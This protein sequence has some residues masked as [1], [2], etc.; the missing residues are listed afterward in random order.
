[1]TMNVQTFVCCEKKNLSEVVLQMEMLPDTKRPLPVLIYS[2]KLNTQTE[3]YF[4][5]TL[6]IQLKY[7]FSGINVGP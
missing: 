5:K 6:E 2:F 3:V 7:C 4:R 1:M